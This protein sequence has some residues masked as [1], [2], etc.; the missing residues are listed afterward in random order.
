MKSLRI[1]NQSDNSYYDFTQE[2]IV[3]VEGLEYA[4]TKSVFD[5]VFGKPGT[6]YVTSSFGRRNISFELLLPHADKFTN[7]AN[8]VS[9]LRE[10]GLIKLIK[11]TTFDDKLLQFEADIV[12]FFNPY[13]KIRKVMTIGM[14][15]PDFRIYSQTEKTTE[16]DDGGSEIAVNSGDEVSNP[17]LR[18]YGPGT[19]FTVDNL[20]T[21]EQIVLTRSLVLGDY[22]DINTLRKTAVLN[23]VSN[24]YKDITGDFFDL[25]SGNNEI[26]LTVTGGDANSILE[27]IFR[28]AYR[29]I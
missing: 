6:V 26:G 14:V 16:V 24:V 3:S 11:F 5:D 4:E 13:S 18:V 22:V 19:V 15:A 9:V 28:D 8:L 25:E 20:T 10:T 27:V 7:R 2:N 12:K 21:S 23:G 17:V 29:G 1:I